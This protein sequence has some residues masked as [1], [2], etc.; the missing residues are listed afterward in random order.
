MISLTICEI[1]LRDVIQDEQVYNDFYEQFKSTVVT[2]IEKGFNRE[3]QTPEIKLLWKEI[4]DE[5]LLSM[6]M[7]LGM[8]Y[9]SF[10]EINSILKR[11][12]YDL[13]DPKN[14]EY[15]LLVITN[16][17]RHETIRKLINSEEN[18][19]ELFTLFGDILSIQSEQALS[20]INNTTFPGGY[21][22]LGKT[23]LQLAAY[24]FIQRFCEKFLVFYTEYK[25][26]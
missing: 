9:D 16:F 25:D 26:N 10:K 17:A 3:F 2:I 15:A 24:Q 20:V 22:D 19:N 8:I 21:Q 6:S 18:L 5:C 1:D 11:S 7:G 23:D 13:N 12:L 14:R 4:Y